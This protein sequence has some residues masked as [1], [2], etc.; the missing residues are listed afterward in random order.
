ML[1]FA[2]IPPFAVDHNLEARQIQRK[3]AL[4]DQDTYENPYNRSFRPGCDHS[5]DDGDWHNYHES[6]DEPSGQPH[7]LRTE[8]TGFNATCGDDSD[9]LL[10]HCLPEVFVDHAAVTQHIAKERKCATDPRFNLG[11]ERRTRFVDYAY[12]ERMND[13]KQRSGQFTPRHHIMPS[14]ADNESHSVSSAYRIGQYV[15]GTDPRAFTQPM[16]SMGSAIHKKPSRPNLTARQPMV[17]ASADVFDVWPTIES[18]YP[19]MVRRPE[20]AH[21]WG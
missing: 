9:Q 5:T 12:L 14:T 16:T 4:D 20:N 18:D 13:I 7:V 10:R 15:V 1:R 8:A 2:R 11:K 6:F 3:R 21:L 17:S 19:V